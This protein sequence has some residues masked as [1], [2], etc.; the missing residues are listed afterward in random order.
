MICAP[1]AKK[2]IGGGGEEGKIYVFYD[3][4]TP[5]NNIDLANFKGNANRDL[6]F[7]IHGADQNDLSGTSV[8]T[9]DFNDGVSNIIS[10]PNDKKDVEGT[11]AEGDNYTIYGYAG[12]SFINMGLVDL[13]LQI[14]KLIHIIVLFMINLYTWL[15]I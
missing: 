13:I 12:K 14:A 8:A 5:R 11:N 9:D 15:F 3:Q 10:A 1:K 2:D 4:S 6:G 7:I